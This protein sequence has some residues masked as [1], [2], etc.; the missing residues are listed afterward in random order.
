MWLEANQSNESLVY[1]DSNITAVETANQN[2]KCFM[3][4]FDSESNVLP[5]ESK[6]ISSGATYY[7]RVDSKINGKIVKGP[8][9][10]F[11]VK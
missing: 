5:L 2:S 8:I 10:T 7:W 1:F 4:S 6:N 9:W 3:G 11:K